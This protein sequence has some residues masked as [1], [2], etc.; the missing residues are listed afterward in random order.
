MTQL[1]I[2][3][4]TL[5]KKHLLE[6]NPKS[7]SAES[8][9]NCPAVRLKP[10]ISINEPLLTGNSNTVLSEINHSTSERASDNKCFLKLG[11]GIIGLGTGLAMMPV[12]NNK[13]YKLGSLDIDVHGSTA[14]FVISTLNTLI[15]K[16]IF[17]TTNSYKYFTKEPQNV[18][19][20]KCQKTTKTIGYTGSVLSSAVPIGML[21]EIELN[22]RKVAKT[23]GFDQFIAWATFTCIALLVSETIKNSDSVDRLVAKLDNAQQEEVVLDSTGAKAVVYLL[24]I[25]GTIGRSVSYTAVISS[26]L[27]GMGLKDDLAETA[28]I[29][30][31]GVILSAIQG[32]SEYSAMKNTFGKREQPLSYMEITVGAISLLEGMWFSLP[33]L[34]YG[35]AYAKEWNPLLK[36]FLFIPAFITASVR[37][38]SSMYNS[39]FRKQTNSNG[40]NIVV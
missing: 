7:K 2:Q 40:L 29:I 27:K 8:T 18:E 35:L 37:E 26:V 28:G 21:W 16:S 38:G 25:L 39:I 19:L 32:A 15:S 11:C 1:S 17:T 6:S 22:N 5:E 30:G 23:E 10:R 34:G 33:S 36:G 13:V 20:N 14:L 3:E 9:K 31:G 4:A 12:F 24:N